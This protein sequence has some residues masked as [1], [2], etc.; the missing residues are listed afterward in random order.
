MENININDF[1][2]EVDK[3]ILWLTERTLSGTLHAGVEKRAEAIVKDDKQTSREVLEELIKEA[4]DASMLEWLKKQLDKK[5]KT[6]SADGIERS[7]IAPHIPKVHLSSTRPRANW[8]EELERKSN[9]AMRE[10]KEIV[11]KNNLKA[12][13]C[14]ALQTLSNDTFEIAKVSTPILLGLVAGG[15][16]TIPLSPMLFAAIAFIIARSGIASFCAGYKKN[17]SEEK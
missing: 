3:A 12:Y 6:I 17:V 16:L 14:P 8:I 4:P 9:N 13:L 10:A 5:S 11:T 15:I 1:L 2:F 7:E